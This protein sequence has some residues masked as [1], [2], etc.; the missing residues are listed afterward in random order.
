MLASLSLNGQF[1]NVRVEPQSERICLSAFAGL[2]LICAGWDAAIDVE[3]MGQGDFF[4][5]TMSSS[6]GR[7]GFMRM[8]AIKRYVPPF[9]S[10]DYAWCPGHLR[11]GL[12]VYHSS[13]QIVRFDC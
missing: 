10:L 6:L 3:M 9:I 2:L 12:K 13:G 1:Y 11:R 8:T 4:V 5:G 7:L